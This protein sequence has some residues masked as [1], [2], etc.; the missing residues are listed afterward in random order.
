MTKREKASL[1]IGSDKIKE[2]D[3]VGVYLKNKKSLMAYAQH[4]QEMSY[5]PV[6]PCDC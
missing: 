2:L 1:F 4:T 5:L 6:F 3:E